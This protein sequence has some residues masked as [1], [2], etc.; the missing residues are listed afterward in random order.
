MFLISCLFVLKEIQQIDNLVRAKMHSYQQTRTTLSAL[1]KKQTG[2][3]LSRDLASLVK[4]DDFLG[5][6]E[7]MST[8]FVV[9]PKFLKEEWLA[10]YE[11][12]SDLVVPRSS[13]LIAEEADQLLFSVIVF[14]KAKKA[15]S[16]A[17]AHK[18]FTVR[19]YVFD[20]EVQ[21][22]QKDE[23]TRLNADIQAQ[24]ANLMRLL[25]T[26]FGEA[27]SCWMHL[28]AVRLY[29]ES[30]LRYGLP[31]SFLFLLVRPLKGP[32]K[33][34]KAILS[35]LDQLS[36]PGISQIDLA[37]AMHSEG[38]MPG[39]MA[40]L[41]D[42]QSSKS[43]DPQ[44]DAQEAAIWNALNVSMHNQFEPFVRLDLKWTI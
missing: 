44:T 2:S 3:L 1:A 32:S 36:L 10:E 6:S 30:L 14:N 28:K 22:V 38:M 18:R 33:L 24:W 34:R 16:E 15:F 13:K 7:F 37:T 5:E 39:G 25:R 21:A 11:K 43:A 12:L 42:Q 29:V 27:F 35:E 9:V 19:E 20:E 31:P 17:A 23:E 40:H 26:N 8:L 41:K 4:K